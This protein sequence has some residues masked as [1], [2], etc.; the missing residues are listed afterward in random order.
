MFQ[1]VLESLQSFASF[2][3]DELSFFE[4]K[5]SVME[6][7][8][9]EYVLRAG[10]ICGAIYFLMEGSCVHTIEQ[11]DE[12]ENVL[13]LYTQYEWLTDY[14]SFTSQKPALASIRAFSDTRLAYID[15][16]S[17][18]GLVQT[19]QS[20]FKAGRLLEKMQYTDIATLHLSPDDKYRHLLHK[21]PQLL[22]A[23]PLKLIA[24]YLRLTP[25]TLS[26]I[27]ARIR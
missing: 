19:S 21:R 27:R 5:L 18:H 1:P 3:S 7:P 17:L 10:D 16:H 13:N 8:A 20:F 9:K 14:Q 4:T 25:E 6:V 26:R 23:F 11:N 24:S 2:T 12:K 15:I 22:Q